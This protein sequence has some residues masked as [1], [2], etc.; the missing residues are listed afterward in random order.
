[1]LLLVLLILALIIFGVGFT[2]HVLWWVLIIILAL[3]IFSLLTGEN[4]L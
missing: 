4:K 3:V 2:V 1:M